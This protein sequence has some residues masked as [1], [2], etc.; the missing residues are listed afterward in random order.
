MLSIFVDV[1]SFFFLFFF[2]PALPKITNCF[3]YFPGGVLKKY[4]H[5][6]LKDKCFSLYLYLF[7]LYSELKHELWTGKAWDDGT[8]A[9]GVALKESHKNPA[10]HC[11]NHT[12][13]G[14]KAIL[15]HCLKY[16][17]SDTE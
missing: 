11:L 8:N 15:P 6:F 3:H 1:G 9:A 5:E 10:P 12:G 2:F 7:F 16:F 13:F 4:H 14:M 17:V